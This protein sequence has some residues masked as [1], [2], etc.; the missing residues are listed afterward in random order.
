MSIIGYRPT[1]KKHFEGYPEE[2]KKKL[3]T[4]RPG[5]SGIGSIVFRNE[6]EMLQRVEEEESISKDDFHQ[7]VIAPYKAALECWY[8]DH[9][10]IAMYFK[11]IALTVD[12]VLHPDTRRWWHELKGQGLPKP[13]KAL[14]KYL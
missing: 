8:V 4:S 13:P 6:E 3:A 11:L 14:R 2:A 12:A 1:V 10:S 9:R 5:L 7:N